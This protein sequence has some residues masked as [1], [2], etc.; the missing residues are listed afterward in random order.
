MVKKYIVDFTVKYDI[1]KICGCVTWVNKLQARIVGR[2][3]LYMGS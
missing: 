2:L 1:G 3:S